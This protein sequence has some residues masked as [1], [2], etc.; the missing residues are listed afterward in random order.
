MISVVLKF[1]RRDLTELLDVFLKKA[2]HPIL[3]RFPWERILFLTKAINQLLGGDKAQELPFPIQ[4]WVNFHTA[5][6]SYFNAAT[7]K[8]TLEQHVIT[9]QETMWTQLSTEFMA[10]LPAAGIIYKTSVLPFRLRL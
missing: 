10:F 4:W 3:L 9:A 7:L 2:I 8:A 1:R 5:V 6:M